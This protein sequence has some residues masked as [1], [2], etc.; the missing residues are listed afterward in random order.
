INGRPRNIRLRATAGQHKL[1]IT[2][3]QRSFAESDER[4]R[5]VAL[6]GGQERLQAAHA[7]QIRGPLSVTG[8][9]ESA[10]RA[11]IFICQPASAKGSVADSS[12]GGCARKIV[13]NLARR[14]FR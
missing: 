3:V 7:L 2:F 6:E 9:S 1:A 8:M 4:T 10:S 11:K 14:E 13:E 12:E 5:T